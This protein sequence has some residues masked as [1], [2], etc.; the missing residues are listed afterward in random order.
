MHESQSPYDFFQPRFRR[1]TLHVT[2]AAR[3]ALMR[4][5]IAVAALLRRHLQGDWGA[6]TPRQAAE[7]ER[8]VENDERIVSRFELAHDVCVWI[9][10]EADRRMTT[11]MLAAEH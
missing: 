1:G 9:V 11:L 4:E 6:V 10:T 2:Y 7:N 8:A 5:G 3:E